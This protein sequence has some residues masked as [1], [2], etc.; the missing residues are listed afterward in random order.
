ML[1]RNITKINNSLLSLKI[2]MLM[3]L[4]ITPP[5]APQDHPPH[6][7]GAGTLAPPY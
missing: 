1:R 3:L 6:S 2:N 7:P 4:I 5:P